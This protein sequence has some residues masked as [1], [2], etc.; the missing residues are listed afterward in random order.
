MRGRTKFLIRVV[1]SAVLLFVVI[2]K[3]DWLALGTILRRSNVGM[4]GAGSLLTGLS[5]A[6]LALRWR[7]FLRQQKFELTFPS[8][9]SLT[10]T[11]QFLNS[12]LPGSTG[13]DV[14][15]I[16]QL[17]RLTPTRKVAAAISVLIDR[18][19]ALIALVLL[20][21][22]GAIL[23]PSAV[24]L[25]TLSRAPHVSLTT[26]I[27]LVALFGAAILLVR[28]FL[29]TVLWLDRVRAAIT[30]AGSAATSLAAP[31]GIALALVI[32]LVNFFVAY[33]FAQALGLEISYT[34]VL[35]F[36]PVLLLFVMVPITV[37]GHGLRELLLITYFQQ[38]QIRIAY[39]PDVSYRDAAVAFSLLLVTNDFLWSLAGGARY[40]IQRRNVQIA[41]APTSV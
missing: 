27:G 20:A 14:Y 38:M 25:A 6:A 8:I 21:T 35:V 9:L 40:L 11:G 32:H 1:V 2:T 10:W 3:V 17:C 22:I 18:L 4:L 39:R 28:R 41:T 36:M 13:G 5:I 23:Q 16:V 33:L 26:V 30:A 12:I 37:N 34:Q 19:S 29:R 24:P 31:V 15:K 7:T